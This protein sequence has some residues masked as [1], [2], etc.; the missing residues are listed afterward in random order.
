MVNATSSSG[1]ALSKTDIMYVRIVPH[2]ETYDFSITIHDAKAFQTACSVTSVSHKTIPPTEFHRFLRDLIILN[3]ELQNVQVLIITA[4][5]GVNKEEL[6]QILLKN[7]KFSLPGIP[8]YLRENHTEFCLSDILVGIANSTTIII[9]NVFERLIDVHP[10]I[11][12]IW[13]LV[14]LAATDLDKRNANHI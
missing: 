7:T 6:R 5:E 3:S 11:C 4:E 13:H 1:F 2:L 8:Q 14:D 9:D 10:I 12:S